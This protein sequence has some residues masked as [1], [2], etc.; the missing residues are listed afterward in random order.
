MD[1]R[2]SDADVIAASE[3]EP[4]RFALIFERHGKSIYAYLRR[5]IGAGGADDLAAETFT[6]AFHKRSSYD[7]SRPNARPWLFGIAANHLRHHWRG[8]RRQLLAYARSGSDPVVDEVDAV[9]RRVD[10]TGVA[11]QLVSAL[12]ALNGRDR[13]AL[14]LYAWADLSYEEIGQALEI[15]TGT[16]RSRLS[17]AR[18]QVRELLAASGQFDDKDPACQRSAQWM[19]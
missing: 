4:E 19:T 17:R 11:E 14:L 1:E 12:A 15:P 7:R 10:A 5:R 2:A 9:E 18:L 3:A 16:V 6:S 8:E 13:E